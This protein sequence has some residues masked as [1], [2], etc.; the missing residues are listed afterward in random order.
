MRSYWQLIEATRD[1][2]FFPVGMTVAHVSVDDPIPTVVQAALI[3]CS[4][5]YTYSEKKM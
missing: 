4:G 1:T 5:V 2:V 3:R